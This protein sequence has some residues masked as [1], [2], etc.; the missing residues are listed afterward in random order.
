MLCSLISKESYAACSDAAGKATIN[1]VYKL[2][3]GTGTASFIEI[4]I[5]DE[6]VTSAVYDEWT[7]Q[8]CYE[9]SNNN[10]DCKSYNVSDFT[11]NFPWLYIQAP[12]FEDEYLDFKKGFDITLRGDA[13]DN[14]G[15]DSQEV[16]DY[17]VTEDFFE[18]DLDGCSVDDLPYWFGSLSTNN[19]TKLAK[20]ITDGT[21]SWE[22]VN[23]NDE[24]E[25]PG[26]NNDG[27][28]V[29]H[30]EIVHDGNGLTCEAEA[31][32]IKACADA[33]CSTLINDA[34]DVQLSINGTFDKTVTISGGSTD[35]SFSFTNVG[36]ATLSLDQTYEC[37]NTS[38]NSDGCSIDFAEAGF[39]LSLANHQ[40][41]TTPNLTIKAVRLSDSGLDCAP[42]YTGNQSVD[43]VFNYDNPS[44]GTEVP[45]LASVDM[46]AATVTQNRTVNFDGTGTANLSFNY[47]DA[48]QIRI[49]VSD[50]AAAGLTS[51]SVTVVVTPAKLIVASSDTDSDCAD[52]DA[53]C[54]VF[55]A[56]GEEFNLDVTAACSDNT[57]TKNFQM[58]N[59]PLTVTT[60]A[61][62]VGNPVSLGVTSINVVAADNGSHN[63]SNQIVSEVGVFTITAT[64]P[65]NSYFGG[66]VPAATSA[67]IGRFIP[68]YFEQT[69]VADG[70]LD[71]VCNQNTAFAYIGQTLVDDATTGAISYLASPV[72]ELT[73]INV[74]GSTTKN[75][76]ETGFMKLIAA[77]NFIVQPATDSTIT[78]KD[79][80]PLPLT[81]NIFAGTVSHDGLVFGEPSFGV[82]LAAGVLHYE[83]ADDDNFFYLRNENSE[84]NAQDNDIDFVIDQAKFIDSD[85][86]AIAAPVNITDTTGINLRFGRAY[87]ENSFGP[88]TANL[89][90]PFSTQYLN[91]SGNW[92]INDQDDCTNFDAAKITLT[93]GTL[94]ATDTGVNVVT[95][96]LDNGE[97]R[98]MLLTAP[99]AGKQGTVNVE[100]DIYDWLKYDWDW[101]GVAAKVFD[102]NPSAVATFGLFRGNDRIIYQ[103]EVNN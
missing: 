2:T 45:S 79:A 96:Q 87:L 62:D 63:V 4:K 52:G 83:L 8:V 90:Q 56:A 29:D 30:Y 95:G 44:S 64:P 69:V 31:I 99:G 47:K 32:T 13:T 34:T 67:N 28:S 98:E 75:Y 26:A 70:G 36:T 91:S 88:E 85:G 15:A 43:F 24:S 80:N 66:T 14:G 68:A 102:E 46:A 25:T 17:V 27:P 19:G 18:Q 5:I 12:T 50:A 53:T 81:A 103:R 9:P 73:A 58:D 23:F 7:L 55:K 11:D 38:D 78:G 10:L 82:A 65:E 93:D 94:K 54:S 86:V 21:G 57:V 71:A 51:S 92:V 49:D 48:G 100:Y 1:E 84:V 40:S 20:R 77:A 42:A 97:T 39:L 61:P 6:V 101:N 60:I 22:I 41:C 35:T 3:T 59:I 37:K 76:T 16:I 33:S 89:P 74:L 72:V